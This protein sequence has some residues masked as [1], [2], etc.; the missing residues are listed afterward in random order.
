MEKENGGYHCC[1]PDSPRSEYSAASSAYTDEGPERQHLL[2]LH[3]RKNAL[4]N[5]SGGGLYRTQQLN[6]QYRA[7]KGGG[8]HDSDAGETADL[9]MIPEENDTRNGPSSDVMSV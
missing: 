5:I 8:A 3:H 4:N 7:S 1:S 9:L 2:S 6:P